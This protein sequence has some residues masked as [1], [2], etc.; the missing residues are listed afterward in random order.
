M[1]KLCCTQ[2]I[3]KKLKLDPVAIKAQE[4]VTT[5]SALGDWYA[6]YIINERQHAIVMVNDRTRMCLVTTAKDT[7]H[8]ESNWRDN[9]F[10][11]HHFKHNNHN[12]HR[13]ARHDKHNYH[14]FGSATSRYRSIY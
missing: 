13:R 1:I 6:K 7:H 2:Q 12:K 8:H 11:Y 3:L 10:N 14:H 4:P 5:T 9:H